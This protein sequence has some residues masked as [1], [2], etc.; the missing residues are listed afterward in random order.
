MKM[1]L[2]DY[3]VWGNDRDGYEVNDVYSALI[4]YDLFH[5]E[6]VYID[7]LESDTDKSGMMAVSMLVTC[8]YTAV[9]F[10]E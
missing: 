7:V 10:M 2:Y 9:V 4:G 3:D 6:N 5:C 8:R 1:K